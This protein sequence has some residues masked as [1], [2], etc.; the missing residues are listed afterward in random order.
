MEAKNVRVL[1]DRM[2]VSASKLKETAAAC[3]ACL[4]GSGNA[5]VQH[6]SSFAQ[7]IRHCSKA[8]TGDCKT[9]FSCLQSHSLR[10]H[11]NFIKSGLPQRVLFHHDDAWKDFPG[12]IITVV[13]GDFQRKKAVT[14][15][16]L[17]NQHVS[18][19]FYHMVCTTLESGSRKPIAWIDENGKCFFPEYILNFVCHVDAVIWTKRDAIH[20]TCVRNGTREP[21]FQKVSVSAAESSNSEQPDVEIFSK[22]EQNE[23]IFSNYQK[24]E[25]LEKTGENEPCSLFPSNFT[26]FRPLQNKSTKPATGPDVYSAV[27][28]ILLLGLRRYVCE[29]DI[30]GIFRTPLLDNTGQVRFKR[31]QEKVEHT[32]VHR[33]NAN[34]RYAWLSSAKDAVEDVMLKGFMTM[35]A[36]SHGPSFGVGVHLAPANCSDICASHSDVDENGIVYMMLCRVIMGNVELIQP[37]SK[38]F[39]PSNEKFDSG[40]DDLQKPKHYV[41]WDTNI[42]THI[43]P[44]FVVTFRM[45]SKA[46]ECLNGKESISNLSGL[47]N[48]S[49]SPSKEGMCSLLPSSMKTSQEKEQVASGRGARTP[50]SPW[51]PFSML[52]AAISTKVLPQDMDLIN[53]H[54]EEFKRRKITRIDLVKKLRQIIGDKLLI[55]T[56]TRLQHK[57]PP[58]ARSVGPKPWCKNYEAKE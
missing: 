20:T 7:A 25:L 13:Q 50:T 1:D 8:S 31:F 23:E 43:Y 30:V 26:G 22:A 56:I 53:T 42:D 35:K 33:G 4:A 55:S 10:N 52:F 47:T 11:Q 39:Q 38:Q 6:E 58:V 18:L 9:N 45:P 48:S 36:P 41:V 21:E 2:F 16:I 34:V 17:D 3:V 14:E 37:G 28:N 12:G 57:L 49:S 46:K 40:V 29:K 5:L 54:Y 32:K 51:M 19:D 15:V 44:E 24:H 27:Q